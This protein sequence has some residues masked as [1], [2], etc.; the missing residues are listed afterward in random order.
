MSQEY[1]AGAVIPPAG[2]VGPVM[3]GV[4]DG[5]VVPL[6]I[7][8]DSE[9]GQDGAETEAETQLAT[10][11]ELRAIRKGMELFLNTDLMALARGE[12]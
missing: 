1:R 9:L 5:V 10:L 12:E 3:H 8:D 7:T 11:M 6:A 2:S 4:K